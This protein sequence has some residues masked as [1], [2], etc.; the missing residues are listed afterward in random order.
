[1]NIYGMHDYKCDFCYDA[2]LTSGCSR[3][4]AEPSGVD[5]GRKRRISDDRPTQAAV[6][7][8]DRT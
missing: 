2:P 1:M 7:D 4:G 3:C 6:D 5:S 8:H